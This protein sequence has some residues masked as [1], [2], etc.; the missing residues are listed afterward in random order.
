MQLETFKNKLDLKEL[1]LN[2]LLEITQSINMNLSEESLYKIYH[3]T[4]RA[5]LNIKKLALFV[6]DE[7]WK[8]R[9]NFGTDHDFQDD[10][11]P[12]K[13]FNVREVKAINKSDS[14]VFAEFDTLIPVAQKD[15]LLAVVFVSNEAQKNQAISFNFIQALSNIILVAIENKKLARR[16]LRQEAYKKELEIASQVQQLLFPRSLPQR[17]DLQ[18]EASYLPHHRVGGDYYDYLEINE[19]QFLICI[20]DVSGKGVPAAILM[21]NFQASLRT[22]A[23]ITSD[24]DEIVKELNYQLLQNAKGEN[25][26]T[27]FIG[28]Y[29]RKNRKLNYVNAGHNPPIYASRQ[30][31]KLLETGTTIM[32]MFHPLPFLN[33]GEVESMED[34]LLFSYTDG[35][36]ETVNEVD[37][38]Y[39][40]ERIEQFICDHW[41]EKPSDIHKHLL[42]EV[43]VFK[44]DRDYTDDITMLSCKISIKN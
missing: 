19:D 34:C 17:K 41:M 24:L 6:L 33:V 44:G 11:L 27:F 2:S 37:E 14:S 26:I 16:Q 38:L 4:L 43:N 29:D 31:T 7:E 30:G 5:N 28:I 15:N 20:A 8:C 18:I 10:S 39:G 13:Y 12:E 21:S 35:L 23:R 9:V 22:L 36:S 42:D 1:E 25:F 32:G 40:F 3:F